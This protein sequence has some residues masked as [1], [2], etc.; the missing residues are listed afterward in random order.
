M[1]KRRDKWIHVKVSEKE[2][3]QWQAL[4]K[5]KGVSV[6]DLVRK[7]VGVQT[8]GT[9]PKRKARRTRQADPALLR[10]LARLGNNLN[11][12]ARWANTYKSS[13][14]AEAVIRALLSIERLL[15]SYR[16][17]QTQEEP[18]EEI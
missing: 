9:E 6:A 7:S 12:I 13:A 4:A 14:E 5:E 3:E 1:P 16:P 15:F 2:R 18:V 17:K 10:E 8:L 11:Q